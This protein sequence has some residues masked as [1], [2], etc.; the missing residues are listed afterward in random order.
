MKIKVNVFNTLGKPVLLGNVLCSLP[1]LRV[2]INSKV[3]VSV[4][5]SSDF[6]SSERHPNTQRGRS[7]FGYKDT[8]PKDSSPILS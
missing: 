8:S 3:K 7:K 5:W 6:W 4:L 2:E 1:S